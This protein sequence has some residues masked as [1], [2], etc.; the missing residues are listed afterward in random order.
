[1]DAVNNTESSRVYEEHDFVIHKED[2][3]SVE[4]DGS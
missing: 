2:D 4:G 1:M 3:I